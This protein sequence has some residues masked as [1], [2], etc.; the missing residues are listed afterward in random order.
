MN[1]MAFQVRKSNGLEQQYHCLPQFKKIGNCK[2]LHNYLQYQIL[3]WRIDFYGYQ[4]IT[5]QTQ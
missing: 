5:K 3:S 4:P 2:N 1:S